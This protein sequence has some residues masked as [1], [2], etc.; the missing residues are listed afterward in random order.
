MSL[1]KSKYTQKP[2]IVYVSDNMSGKMSGIPCISTSVALNPICAA[3]AKNPDSICAHCFAAATVARYT[4]L[5]EHLA[6]NT[7]TL[8]AP[9]REEDI[10]LF[11]YT[12]NMVRFEAFGDTNNA[13][14]A[15]NY[16]K[17]AA[18]NPCV[19]FAVWTKNP[20]HY[21]LAIAGG[22]VKPPNLIIVYSSPLL[23]KPE[24]SVFER[25]PF[26]DKVFTVYD[27]KT[28]AEKNIIINCGA[29]SCGSCGLCYFDRAI[30]EVNEQLK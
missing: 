18:A 2:C 11:N 20:K 27:K 14:Q 16:F 3:R 7:A 26:I 9:L 30:K 21:E 12:V 25:Y 15:A 22:A 4:K 17:I 23:N 24:T 5:G 19:R 10:P 1:Y 13:T 8:T 29:R 28:I 6:E